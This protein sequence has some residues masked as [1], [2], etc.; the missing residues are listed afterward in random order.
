MPPSPCG[1]VACCC[2]RL[3]HRPGRRCASRLLRRRGSPLRA[4]VVAHR[5]AT[6]P[7]DEEELATEK[8]RTKKCWS[9]FKNVWPTFSWKCWW[10]LLEKLLDPTFLST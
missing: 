6:G 9:I 5:A 3:D 7:L 10:K 4:A 2:A 1:Q 8:C